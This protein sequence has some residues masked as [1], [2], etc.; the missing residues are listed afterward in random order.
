MF[1]RHCVIAH[2]LEDNSFL[3]YV[4]FLDADMAVINPNHLIEDYIINL[5]SFDLIFSE[6]IFTNEIMAGS[7]FVKLKF[8]F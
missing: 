8:C 6:R 4:L 7:Y 1:A 2:F 5:L 3:N